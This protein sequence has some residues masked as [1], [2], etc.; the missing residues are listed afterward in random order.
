MTRFWSDGSPRKSGEEEGLSSCFILIIS[1]IK[2]QKGRFVFASFLGVL[3]FW[4]FRVVGF[5]LIVTFH[6]RKSFYIKEDRGTPY[7]Y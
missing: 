6:L 5:V 1:E 3:G 2:V 4:G 7:L